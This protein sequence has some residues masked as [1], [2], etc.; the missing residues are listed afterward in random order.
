MKKTQGGL[1][2][3]IQSRIKTRIKE[4]TG[5][6]DAGGGVGFAVPED[7]SGGTPSSPDPIIEDFNNAAEVSAKTYNES[8]FQKYKE[9]PEDSKVRIR[10]ESVEQ[11]FFKARAIY[12]SA[13]SKLL[14]QQAA[15]KDLLQTARNFAS[16]LNKSFNSL[17]NSDDT[18]VKNTIATLISNYDKNVSDIL[19]RYGIENLSDVSQKF[20]E[21]F[22]HLGMISGKND[23]QGGSFYDEATTALDDAVSE[24]YN[25]SSNGSGEILR[26]YL[27]I[28]KAF[29]KKNS[30]IDLLQKDIQRALAE[31]RAKPYVGVDEN[32]LQEALNKLSEEEKKQ[33]FNGFLTAEEVLQM[34]KSKSFKTYSRLL[35]ESTENGSKVE[36]TDALVPNYRQA[37]DSSPRVCGNCRFFN[38]SK[39]LMGTCSAFDFEAKANHV[40]DA[41]QGQQL[42]S[43]HTVVRNDEDYIS[44]KA[45]ESM[46]SNNFLSP[47]TRVD[48]KP[49]Q[50][51][52]KVPGHQI[53]PLDVASSQI[54]VEDEGINFSVQQ[55]SEENAVMRS[56][57]NE[58]L[59]G[60]IVY[61]KA[62]R[63]LGVVEDSKMVDGF[64]LYSLKLIDANG[65]SWGSGFSLKSDLQPRSSSATKA[66][67][68]S[69]Y[70]A[71]RYAN[72]AEEN[73]V[74]E[75]LTVDID[76]M[77]ET[78]RTVYKAL[79]TVCEE[80]ADVLKAP[81]SNQNVLNPIRQYLV[82]A[83]NRDTFKGVKTGPKRKYYRAVQTALGSIGAARQ[84]LFESYKT[85]NALRRN[86]LV[87]S[88][89]KAQMQRVMLKG[90]TDA[91]DRVVY[92]K[93]QLEDALTLPSSTHD[94]PAPG[95]GTKKFKR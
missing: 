17:S 5:G 83:L 55:P 4:I 58:F 7:Y 69:H 1:K 52:G 8:M 63:S 16:E 21:A 50:T 35:Q 92:A 54:F 31:P 66:N 85:I 75:D 39:G 70:A 77:V 20:A 15:A 94:I 95:L 12:M 13:Q 26:N 10:A 62:L 33:W 89:A 88:T 90:Q 40:C 43:S 51:Q 23:F 6:S 84:I 86:A 47:I 37:I 3:V 44:S 65:N 74:Q 42:T 22:D 19:K 67:M 14:Q 30:E 68:P 38:G 80:H 61:S 28:Q 46:V 25:T 91:Y 18:T 93:Q 48:G 2:A 9:L 49:K 34:A 73:A 41:W 57:K 64:K 27:K 76:D 60:D 87:D 56:A 11:E 59:P 36:D 79:K 45:D 53:I 78:V 82:E 71:A 29:Q 72:K 24:L 32:E 81:L